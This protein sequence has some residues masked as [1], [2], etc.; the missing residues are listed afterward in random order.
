VKSDRFKAACLLSH[1]MRAN[2]PWIF[3]FQVPDA[4]RRQTLDQ[5]SILDT[6]TAAIHIGHH[7]VR[8]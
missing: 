4:L 1:Q 6:E 3:S 5:S 2:P 8:A 7:E